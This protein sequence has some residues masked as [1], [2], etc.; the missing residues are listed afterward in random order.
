MPKQPGYNRSYEAA[1]KI[2]PAL[3]SNSPGIS[4]K[5]DRKQLSNSLLSTHAT[6]LWEHLSGG[7]DKEKPEPVV[8]T[9]SDATI[10]G[11]MQIVIEPHLEGRESRKDTLALLI[12]ARIRFQTRQD[13]MR[14]AL[15]RH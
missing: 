5:A 10:C 4:L 9:T 3:W 7:A 11:L 13:G 2:K 8:A 6:H 1:S 12:D 15:E 14:N